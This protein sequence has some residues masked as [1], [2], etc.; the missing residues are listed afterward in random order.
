MQIMQ[1]SFAYRN[2]NFLLLQ[3]ELGVVQSGSADID[4]EQATAV[5]PARS[6]L[7]ALLVRGAGD[8]QLS[9]HKLD[10]GDVVGRQDDSAEDLPDRGDLDDGG[11]VIQGV[12]DVAILIDPEPVQVT[13]LLVLVMDA[14][15]GEATVLGVV[16]PRKDGVLRRVGEVHGLA[17]RGPAKAVG[18]DQT[19]LD[20]LL[21]LSKVKSVEGSW[22][23]TNAM[24]ESTLLWEKEKK[25]IMS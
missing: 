19:R 5:L 13:L 4:P 15:V 22:I 16:V 2:N 24:S 1:I 25:K 17:I 8:E 12:P 20:L 3:F 7:L 10:A 18:D 9:T 14:L 11:S 21:G 23:Q 6:P